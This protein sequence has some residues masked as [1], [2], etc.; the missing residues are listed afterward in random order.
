MKN[1]KILETYEEIENAMFKGK[2][3]GLKMV[4]ED[5]EASKQPNYGETAAIKRAPEIMYIPTK[6]DKTAYELQLEN[7]KLRGLLKKC[8]NI[9]AHDCWQ[10]AQFPDGQIVERQDLLTSINTALGGSEE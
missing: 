4:I 8:K 7:N 1:A 6:H 9:V 10:E 2:D 5:D 3:V